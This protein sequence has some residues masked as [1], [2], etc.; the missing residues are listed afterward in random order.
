MQQPIIS[1]A[2]SSGLLDYLKEK[3]ES[4]KSVSNKPNSHREMTSYENGLKMMIN[5]IMLTSPDVDDVDDEK[6]LD[7]NLK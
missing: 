3:K 7:L 2:D 4:F 1:K 5:N 6:D